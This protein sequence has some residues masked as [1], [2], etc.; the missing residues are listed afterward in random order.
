MAGGILD[1][2][3]DTYNTIARQ[4]PRQ[5]IQTGLNFGL[6]IISALF[7]WK[8]CIIVSG[9]EAPIVVVLTGSMEPSFKRGDL[10]F[11][12]NNLWAKSQHDKYRVGEILVYKVPRIIIVIY[13]FIVSLFLF[14]L[15]FVFSSFSLFFSFSFLT[16]SFSHSFF[17]FFF[18]DFSLIL[19]FSLFFPIIFF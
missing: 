12:T 14:P 15:S 13:I 10:L 1:E 7:I 18:L 16:F 2:L 4:R 8:M 5:M 6:V 17:F 9:C 3:K 19:L 11:L